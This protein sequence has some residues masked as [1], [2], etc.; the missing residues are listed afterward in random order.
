MKNILLLITLAC[1]NL[2]SYSQ[3][4][5]KL[6]DYEFSGDKIFKK[7][8]SQV[9]ECTNYLL[10]NPTNKDEL[11]RL[12]SMQFIMKWMEGTPDYTF[13]IGKKA[14]DLTKGNSDLLGLYLAAMTKTVLD[15]TNSKLNDDDIHENAKKLLVDYCSNP[16]NNIKPSKTIK[17]ILKKKSKT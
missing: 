3:D 7:S 17:K 2:N 13:N 1:L 12:N 4:Y 5:S 14:M 6:K 9:L 10:S 16:N 15:N 11:N 8:E